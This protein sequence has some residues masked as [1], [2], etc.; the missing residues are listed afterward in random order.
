MLLS[1]ICPVAIQDKQVV[2]GQEADAFPLS[3]TTIGI[4]PT[5]IADA[6]E[7]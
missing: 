1:L 6:L 5:L 2:R 7:I 3:L 4:C